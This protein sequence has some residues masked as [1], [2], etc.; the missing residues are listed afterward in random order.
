LL[1]ITTRSGRN[2]STFFAS[3]SLVEVFDEIGGC[4]KRKETVHEI[5][6][7][8]AI[9][10][11]K[12]WK[13][14]GLVSVSL[15]LGIIAWL[16]SR[17]DLNKA[18]LLIQTAHWE[19]LCLAGLIIVLIPFAH[20]WRWRGVLRAQPD[21]TISFKSTLKAVLMANAVNSM[22]PSKAGDAV[23]IFYIKSQSGFIIGAGT[24]I[25]ERMVDL[26]VLSSLGLVC[27][28]AYK[29]TWALWVGLGLL[30]VIFGFLFTVLIINRYSLSTGKS[31][32]DNVKAFTSVFSRWVK[33]PGSIIQT[34]ASSTCS[35]ALAGFTVCCLITA[36]GSRVPWEYAYSIYPVAVLAGLVPT[37]ISG[38]GTRDAAFV[39]L[40]SSYADR[41]EATL[42]ALGYTIY[43]YWFLS[44]LGV[45]V[46]FRELWDWFR[47]SRTLLK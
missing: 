41:E 17:I 3:R 36:V 1:E 21:L 8:L 44:L 5:K 4:I 26:M 42:I 38:L 22:V 12:Q 13:L 39:F 20:T 32:K 15:S 27:Y 14:L 34:F 40:L 23:K 33:H 16:L 46:V 25:L 37:T 6:N 19:W 7:Q 29:I 30:T 2:L 28:F 47:G 18:K 43:N 9:R 10:K 45:P 31:I 11:V 35:W 24:V